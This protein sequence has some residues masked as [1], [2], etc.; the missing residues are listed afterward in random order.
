MELLAIEDIRNLQN[1]I[2]QLYTL[3]NLDTFPADSLSIVHQLVPSDW[4]LFQHT[5][6]RTGQLWLTNLPHSQELLMPL[7]QVQLLSQ[8]LEHGHHPIAQNMPQALQGAYKLS[9]FISQTELHRQE[10]LYQ[11][12]LRLL[13]VEDQMLLFLPTTNAQQWT[14]LAQANTTIS[15]FI[16][17]RPQCNFTEQERL[18]LNLL[19]PHLGQAYANVQHYQKLQQN[20]SQLQQSCHQLGLIIVDTTGRVQSIASSALTLLESYFPKSPGVQQL[21]EH[22]WSWVKHQVHLGTPEFNSS[23]ARLPLRIQQHGREL[24]IRLVVESAGGRYL[25]LLA[26]EPTASPKQSLALLGLSPR[27][28]E[29]LALVMEG[30]DNKAIAL[31]LAVGVST[32]RKHL[33]NIYQKLG[34]QSRTEAIAQAL[35]KLGLFN[36]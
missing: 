16:L 32:V 6:T 17:N 20:F 19:R 35:T 2:Q 12:F 31:Q 9:D 7:A 30:K 23:S 18:I 36:S 13:G 29:V 10:K 5:N 11:Q 22:L 8:L 27:E 25:L 4:P 14:E 1:S 26:E 34:V 3:Q 24:V 28:T 15:G 21:P 33:E